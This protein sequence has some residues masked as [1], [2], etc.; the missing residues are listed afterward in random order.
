M[1]AHFF[2]ACQLHAACFAPLSKHIFT[3]PPAPSPLG[4]DLPGL[5]SYL[6]EALARNEGSL[7]SQRELWKTVSG[8]CELGL[9]LLVC[10]K[11]RQ[12]TEERHGF[13]ASLERLTTNYVLFMDKSW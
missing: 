9:S 13:V 2:L 6:H 10:T 11:Q 1:I 7:E 5:A 8:A 12:R 3:A 4:M